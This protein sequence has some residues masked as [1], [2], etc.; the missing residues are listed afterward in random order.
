MEPRTIK[1]AIPSQF[2]SVSFLGESLKSICALVAVPDRE[3]H[4]LELSVVEAL[5]NVIEHAY[6]SRPS[7]TIEVLVSIM[8]RKVQVEIRD[9]GL[10]MPVFQEPTLEYDENNLESLPEGGMGRYLMHQMMDEIW[11]G[12]EAGENQLILQ[13]SYSPRR[14]SA[15][16]ASS[17]Q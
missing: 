7:G 9:Q 2:E 11:Y 14:E 5:N 17:K 6:Q 13:K 15:K 12:H 16:M 3:T 10:P 8:A 1:F 4:Y